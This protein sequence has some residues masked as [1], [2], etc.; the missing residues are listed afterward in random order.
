MDDLFQRGVLTYGFTS[1]AIFCLEWYMRDI[2][3]N[4]IGNPA[5]IL[6]S[7]IYTVYKWTWWALLVLGL[8]LGVQAVAHSISEK[9]RIKN[10]KIKS[11]EHE[12][13]DLEDRAR[14]ERV[15]KL[16]ERRRK[17]KLEKVRVQQECEAR[18]IQATRIKEL[19]ERSPDDA[20]NEALKDFF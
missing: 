5:W 8:I 14:K 15:E 4:Y 3:A 20:I 17:R 12:Q 13:K 18:E 2:G 16:L 11:R 1:L 6:I 10:E 9:T 19:K 7:T